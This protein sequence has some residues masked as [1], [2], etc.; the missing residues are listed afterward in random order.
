MTSFSGIDLGAAL[1]GARGLVDEFRVTDEER[2]AARAKLLEIENAAAAQVLA[3]ETAIREAQ[4]AI[5]VAEAGSESAL[6]RVWR[7]LSMVA[8]VGLVVHQ[9]V[10]HPYLSHW[11]DMP[12]VQLPP[13]LWTVIQV[14]FA[15]YIAARSGEKIVAKVRASAPQAAEGAGDQRQKRKLLK[16]V[17][18]QT[19]RMLRAGLTQA[20]IDELLDGVV[21]DSR[22]KP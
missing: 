17:G 19:R 16:T 14:G 9:Y 4:R 6:A 12:R 8:F 15:G 1:K 18:K 13:D 7:P 2:D 10:I 22:Q 3:Y 11:L 21:G 5:I 20:E